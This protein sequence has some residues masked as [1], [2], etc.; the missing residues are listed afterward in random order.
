L[1]DDFGIL[2]N[3]SGP[4][5]LECGEKAEFW[6]MDSR[7][8]GYWDGCL[9]SPSWSKKYSRNG[10]S[11]IG[12]EK[13]TQANF[14]DHCTAGW[15]LR[16]WDIWMCERHKVKM[17]PCYWVEIP[18]SISV[19]GTFQ[20]IIQQSVRVSPI[21]QAP[22]GMWIND[23]SIYLNTASNNC[24]EGTNFNYPCMPTVTGQLE[25]NAFLPE[26][27]TLNPMPTLTQCQQL[28]KVPYKVTDRGI[29]FC[30]T[31]QFVNNTVSAELE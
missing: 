8:V 7:I 23:T 18:L 11:R 12:G 10:E 21:L 27:L 6:Y 30:T 28:L 17:L 1:K 16:I 3:L 13:Q 19:N 5:K 24:L 29:N 15:K 4:Y 9:G 26:P 14:K 2:Y 22:Y 31:V 25:V 20:Q